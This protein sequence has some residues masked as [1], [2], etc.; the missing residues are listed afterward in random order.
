MRF[1]HMHMRISRLVP[2]VSP[3]EFP[4]RTTTRPSSLSLLR[5]MRRLPA[6]GAVVAIGVLAM[7]AVLDAGTTN[8]SGDS[9]FPGESQPSGL[10]SRL[11]SSSATAGFKRGFHLDHTYMP[12]GLWVPV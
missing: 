4:S 2:T 11:G 10:L 1:L 8:T 12:R 7:P 5:T 6:W 3:K 9:C